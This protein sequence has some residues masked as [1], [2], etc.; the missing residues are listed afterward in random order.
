MSPDPGSKNS[1]GLEGGH[2]LVFHPLC[3]FDAGLGRRHAEEIE[4][5]LDPLARLSMHE[6][7]RRTRH[8]HESSALYDV[9]SLH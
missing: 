7:H 8:V 2:R 9:F 3:V 1:M 4:F 5:A 6:S